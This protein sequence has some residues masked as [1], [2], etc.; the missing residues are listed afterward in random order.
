VPVYTGVVVINPP[1]RG[2]NPKERSS[3]SQPSVA[4]GPPPNSGSST[5]TIAEKPRTPKPAEAPAPSA[6]RGDDQP[7]DRRVA[8]TPGTR[9]E[10]PVHISPPTR[11][12]PAPVNQRVPVAPVAKPT[13]DVKPVATPPAASAPGDQDKK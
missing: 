13:H 7:R 12:E 6:P 10:A 3:G 11:E 5:R 2:A 1:D 8:T 4:P 9:T